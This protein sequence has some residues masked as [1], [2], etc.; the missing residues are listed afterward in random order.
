MQSYF[1]C[2]M[3]GSTYL[4]YCIVATYICR[5]VATVVAIKFCNCTAFCTLT[6]YVHMKLQ[7]RSILQVLHKIAIIMG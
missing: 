7:I 1:L 3:I 6:K 4:M 2:S 5:Y